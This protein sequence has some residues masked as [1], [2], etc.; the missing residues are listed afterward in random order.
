M[1]LLSRGT[2]GG[3]SLS[4]LYCCNIRLTLQGVEDVNLRRYLRWANTGDLEDAERKTPATG[5]L[6]VS[7]EPVQVQGS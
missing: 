4:F 1:L 2:E 5:T 3:I 6:S 7:S